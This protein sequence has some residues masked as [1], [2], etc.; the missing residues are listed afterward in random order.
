MSGTRT[1]ARPRPATGCP[2]PAVLV[3][4]GGRIRVGRAWPHDDTDA[5]GSRRITVEGSDQAGRIRAGRVLLHEGRDPRVQLSPSGV[6]RRLPQLAAATALGP[7]VSHR[8]GKRAVIRGRVSYLK[9]VRPGQAEDVAARA[10]TGRRLAARA[11]LAAPQVLD[12][13]DGTVEFAVLPGRTLHVLGAGADLADWRLW[14]TSWSRAW[15]ALVDG[16]TAG[17]PT[18]DAAREAVTL[19]R[20]AARAEAFGAFPAHLL[21]GYRRQ[22]RDVVDELRRGP[23]TPLAV[24]HRDLH[25]KQILAHGD[26][27]G[28]LD[29]D[30]A[31][32]AE[33][34]L[35]LAN[36]LVHVDLR[37]RQGRWSTAHADLAGAAIRQTAQ[38]MGVPTRRLACYA[39]ATRL[40]LAALYA[41]RPLHHRLA[42]ESA[43]DADRFSW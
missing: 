5:D 39:A 15:P 38:L 16:P 43:V 4:D 24:A 22:V 36:L 30:T 26:R 12:V 17:L 41:F 27:L 14:W 32:L 6:D 8:L 25:D 31:A 33:P 2:V 18:H 40:R 23:A 34:A 1:P 13:T 29:F 42:V 20:W 10:E 37:R 21:P 3:T 9:V 35:D 28:L 7:L 11:G 19:S